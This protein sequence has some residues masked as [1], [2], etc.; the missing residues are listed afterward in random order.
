[1]SSAMRFTQYDP[2]G[3]FDEMFGERRRPRP[4][5]RALAQFID[6]LPDGELLSPSAVGRARAPQ[7]GHH[8]QR[9][10]RRRRHRADLPVR[11]RP[12][13]RVGV[14]VAH[15]RARA[16]AADRGAQ[17]VH[18]RHLPRPADPQ[19]RRRA[20][21]RHP[22]GPGVPAAV[23]RA[24]RRRTASGATSP[25]PIWCGTTTARSTCS[26]TTCGVRPACRTCSRTAT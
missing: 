25:A 8:V 10:R 15:H 9:L 12:A 14:G 23:R 21:R 20:V 6:A 16:E 2:E 24:R 4:A 13:H 5:A 3:F 1:M 19:G 17:P 22:L 26:R 18:R 7:H 11:P